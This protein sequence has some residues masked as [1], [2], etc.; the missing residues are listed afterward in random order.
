MPADI[1]VYA[2]VAAGLVFWLRSILGTRHDG[3][4]Q[5]PNPYLAPREGRL[6]QEKQETPGPRE[7]GPGA[8][9]KI[10]NLAREA[11]GV[12]SIGDEAAK[13]GLLEIARNEKD[14]DVKMFLNSAQEAFAIIVEAFAG[15]DRE[16]LQDLLSPS[17]YR[18]FAASLDTRAQSGETWKTEIHTVSKA[19]ILEARIRN[20]TA[21][22]TVRF[23][24][25]E[26]SVVQDREGNILS[27]HPDKTTKIKDVWV[28]GRTLR[29]RDPRWL[30]HETR[31]D[32]EGDNQAIP[33]SD[34]NA[35]LH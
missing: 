27:G 4:R 20:K 5:R 35:F 6:P 24:A 30:V 12:F 33:N 10:E 11:S 1:F 22:I 17:V 34:E 31:G 29:S 15:G 21:C 8:E 3:E 16:T 25:E 19:E 32:F 18:A 9:E 28:F 13:N 7:A 26:T 23:T 14:F 2:L